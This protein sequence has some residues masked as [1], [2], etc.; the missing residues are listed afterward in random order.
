MSEVIL[1]LQLLSQLLHSQPSGEDIK[2][3]KFCCWSPSSS[4]LLRGFVSFRCAEML[5]KCQEYFWA[6]DK[7]HAECIFFSLTQ[8]IF[9]VNET[10]LN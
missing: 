10:V 2:K 4:D 9:F 6:C 8:L 3:K 1:L 5:T 7:A